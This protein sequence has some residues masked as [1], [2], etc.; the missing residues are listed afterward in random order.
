M[1]FPV[2]ASLVLILA[3]LGLAGAAAAPTARPASKQAAAAPVAPP[4]TASNGYFVIR[5]TDEAWTVMDP[6]AIERVD[7]GPLRRAYSVTVRRNLLNGGPPQ[8]GYVRTLNEYDCEARRFRWRTFTIYNRFG[9]V[10]VKQDNA[11][12]TFGPPDLR[13]EDDISLRVVCD[14]A[15]G[16]SVVAAPSLGKLVIG[17]MQAW[18]DAAM[19]APLQTIGPGL[20][21]KPVEK[22]PN[23]R[24]SNPGKPEPRTPEPKRADLKAPRR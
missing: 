10:V 23:A 17:L 11:D 6:N 4:V 16:G 9:A 18:D 13:G 22:A 15:G 5:R 24:T 19:A 21:P 8:P 7:G 1:V 14:G 2:R 3:S 12:V 20:G